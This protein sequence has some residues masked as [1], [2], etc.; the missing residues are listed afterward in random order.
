MYVVKNTKLEKLF[1]NNEF[2]VYEKEEYIE[3][4]VNIL[5]N[6]SLLIL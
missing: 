6:I 4:V 1:K 5:E 3:K 2:K